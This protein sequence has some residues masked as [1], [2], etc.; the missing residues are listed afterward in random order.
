[1]PLPD[2]K[3][4]ILAG[5]YGSGK[6]QLAVN[7]ALRLRENG[8]VTLAD[9]DIVNPYFRTKDF[10]SLLREK[11]IGFISSAYA[12]SNVDLPSLSAEVNVVFEDSDTTF[13]LD[14]GGDERGA[15]ALG[16]YAPRMPEESAVLLVFNHY[17]P[18]TRETGDAL[19]I[20]REIEVAGRLRFTGLINNSNLGD[21][22]TPEDVLTSLPYAEALAQKAGLPI[23]ATSVWRPLAEALSPH[24][25]NLLLIDRYAKPQWVI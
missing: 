2:Q 7:L 18:Q 9:L 15:L 21:A 22:T 17:R 16:R 1:M 5:H 25:D 23:V 12:N 8:P 11:D 4:Y 20:V 13:V 10:A 24:I 19:E 6:T 3:L 14:V